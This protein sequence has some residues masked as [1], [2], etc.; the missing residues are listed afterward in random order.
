MIEDVQESPESNSYHDFINRFSDLMDEA[1][2]YGVTA[3]VILHEHDPIA[4]DCG[5]FILYTTGLDLGAGLCA[6]AQRK[7]IDSAVMDHIEGD[8]E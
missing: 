8:D 4:K 7:M 2:S 1:K 5:R 3:V 6:I